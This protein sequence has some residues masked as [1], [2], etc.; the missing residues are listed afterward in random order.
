MNPK[1][2]LKT[3]AILL[4]LALILG[5]FIWGPLS[6]K[7]PEPGPAIQTPSMQNIPAGTQ[8]TIEVEPPDAPAQPAE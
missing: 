2:V 8:L 3:S 5:V 7:A 4:V 1:N 6:Q